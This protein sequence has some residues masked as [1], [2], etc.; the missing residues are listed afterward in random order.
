M[1][2]KWASL[3][4]LFASTGFLSLQLVVPFINV[5]ESGTG[6]LQTCIQMQGTH[7]CPTCVPSPYRGVLMQ[8]GTQVGDVG[9]P[10]WAHGSAD[11]FIRLQREALESDFV[12]EHLNEWV[13]LIFG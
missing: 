3:P 4:T 1:S 7:C 2:Q 9:L 5:K 6:L 12:S 8:T 11:E 13:D 10:A